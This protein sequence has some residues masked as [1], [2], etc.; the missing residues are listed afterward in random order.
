M[1]EA[2]H[3]SD[4]LL[5]WGREG[6]LFIVACALP[7]WSDEA[8]KQTLAGSLDLERHLGGPATRVLSYFPDGTPS[9]AQRRMSVEA[10]QKSRL[11]DRVALLSDSALTRGAFT[12]IQ[13]MLGQQT[14]HKA[15]TPRDVRPAIAWL[16]EGDAFDAE[17]GYQLAREIIT[18]DVAAKRPRAAEP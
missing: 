10:T 4:S 12:A 3:S 18:A 13:W 5:H 9:A 11:A 14:L 1:P 17:V 2:H 8:W 7:T 15:F 6:S 16:A